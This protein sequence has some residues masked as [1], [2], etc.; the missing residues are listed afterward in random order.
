M[1]SQDLVELPVPL[2]LLVPSPPTGVLVSH[3]AV[4][5][6]VCVSEACVQRDVRQVGLT[7]QLMNIVVLM[8]STASRVA[9]V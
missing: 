9:K 7:L 1:S 4:F 5:T 3:L 2:A 8:V 6:K